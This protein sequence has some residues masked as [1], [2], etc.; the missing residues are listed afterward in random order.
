MRTEVERIQQMQHPDSHE[1]AIARQNLNTLYFDWKTSANHDR[2][3]R[4]PSGRHRS[5]TMT[6]HNIPLRR[7]R[8]PTTVANTRSVNKGISKS[9]KS[10]QLPQAVWNPSKSHKYI[11]ADSNAQEEYEKEKRQGKARNKKIKKDTNELAKCLTQMNLGTQR[12]GDQEVEQYNIIGCT[13]KDGEMD[14]EM[15]GTSLS[16]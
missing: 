2:G 10:S 1:L 15:G 6:T 14:M 4:S 11:Q 13:K 7:S 12:H 16:N 5:S 8:R 9:T 3:Y